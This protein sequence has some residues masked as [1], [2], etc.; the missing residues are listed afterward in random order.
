[1]DELTRWTVERKWMCYKWNKRKRLKIIFY[2]FNNLL[3]D[4]KKE[5][6]MISISKL[7]QFNCLTNEGIKGMVKFDRL[8][9]IKCELINN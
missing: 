9:A 7:E 5:E 6:K 8:N 4:N 1:M 2:F 3:D